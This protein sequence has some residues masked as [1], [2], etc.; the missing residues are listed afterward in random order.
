MS[1]PDRIT[2]M[3]RCPYCEQRTEIH[4]YDMDDSIEHHCTRC[5]MVWLIWT[6][7]EYTP[8]GEYADITA[9]YHA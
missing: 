6:D 8:L 9:F 3:H 1:K 7:G 5:D 4:Q 2:R